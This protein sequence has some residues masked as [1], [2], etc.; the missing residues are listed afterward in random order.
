MSKFI[1]SLISGMDEAKVEIQKEL[2]KTSKLRWLKRYR[3]KRVL[4]LYEGLRADVESSEE[5]FNSMFGES[6]DELFG[7][8]DEPTKNPVS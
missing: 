8:Q 3:L 4:K 5:F 6:L 1:D 7:K 2:D